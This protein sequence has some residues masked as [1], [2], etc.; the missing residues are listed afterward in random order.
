M[1]FNFLIPSKKESCGSNNVRNISHTHTWERFTSSVRYR[2]LGVLLLEQ[3]IGLRSSCRVY[4]FRFTIC[5]MC[6]G[7]KVGGRGIMRVWKWGRRGEG[8]EKRKEGYE[9]NGDRRKGTGGVFSIMMLAGTDYTLWG[10][11]LWYL[12]YCSEGSYPS[13]VISI[14][15]VPSSKRTVL[16]L[17]WKTHIQCFFWILISHKINW[18]WLLFSSI[19]ALHTLMQNVQRLPPYLHYTAHIHP[20]ACHLF[21]FSTALQNLTSAGTSMSMPWPSPWT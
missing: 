2:H 1:R 20:P 11:S 17:S 21:L 13:K 9:R 6:G 8:R 7:G 12:K 14:W 18:N 10:S 15:C 4:I 5:M 3:V 16:H 19:Q